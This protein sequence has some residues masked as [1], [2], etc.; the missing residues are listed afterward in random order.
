MCGLLPPL[1]A[2]FTMTKEELDKQ[3]VERKIAKLSDS[4]RYLLFTHFGSEGTSIVPKDY[5][6]YKELLDLNL[7]KKAINY[8]SSSGMGWKPK[9]HESLYILTTFGKMVK[10][11]LVN[12]S[13]CIGI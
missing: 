6:A 8:F 12:N 7:V 4:A 5:P 10:Q 3:V 1:V 2:F 9:D 11:K 13:Y